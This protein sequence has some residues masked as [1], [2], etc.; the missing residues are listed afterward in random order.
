MVALGEYT[1]GCICKKKGEKLSMQDVGE[2][3]ILSSAGVGAGA[4]GVLIMR[5]G[6]S[7]IIVPGMIPIPLSPGPT[8]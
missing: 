6:G 8:F 5:E 7:P 3:I 2:T 1:D 4:I